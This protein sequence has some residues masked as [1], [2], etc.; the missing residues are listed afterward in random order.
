MKIH[1][2]DTSVTLESEDMRYPLLEK[3]KFSDYSNVTARPYFSFYY[4]ESETIWERFCFCMNKLSDLCLSDPYLG[5]YALVFRRLYSILLSGSQAKNVIGYGLPADSAA[6]KV[7]QDFMTFLQEG[8]ALTALAISP[9]SLMAV[10]NG[11]CFALL[12]RLDTCPALAAVCDAIEKVKP[13]GLILLYTVKDSLPAELNALC[14]QAEKDSF[15]SC[16]VYALT[17]DETLADYV[18]TNSSEAFILSQVETLLQCVGD[19]QN[20]TGAMLAGSCSADAYPIAVMILQQTEEILLSL[21]D[22]LEDDELPVRANALKEAV[23]NYYV[24]ISS[25][26]GLTTYVE[27]LTQSSEI[28]YTSIKAEFGAEF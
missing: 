20:L 8:S 16:T 28:L 18:Q 3:P 9:F 4:A 15:G 22:Y 17:M 7:Y 10:A 21:Y 2:T 23:L 13:G 19:L 14:A 11:S 6:Y 24:G 12:Y 25:H 1:V 5:C 26:C 27:K